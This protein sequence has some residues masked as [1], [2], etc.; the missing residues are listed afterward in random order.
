M[1]TA[2][3]CCC[4]VVCIMLAT[5]FNVKVEVMNVIYQSQVDGFS[6]VLKTIVS[7]G[8]EVEISHLSVGIG[9]SNYNN[10]LYNLSALHQ[11]IAS[12]S[13][14]VSCIMIM[15]QNEYHL[16]NNIILSKMYRRFRSETMVLGESWSRNRE[17]RYRSAVKC[18]HNNNLQLGNY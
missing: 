11:W 16:L 14:L 4:L 7:G 5:V 12:C 6:T 9:S 1:T 17:F 8:R 3:F 10:S 13:L 18:Y 2:V 15:N